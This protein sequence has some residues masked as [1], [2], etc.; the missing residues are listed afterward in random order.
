[1]TR[2]VVVLSLL[3]RCLSR[4]GGELQTTPAKIAKMVMACC[5]LHN[6]VEM[7]RLPLPE[8]L[9][10]DANLE[11]GNDVSLFCLIIVV[12]QRS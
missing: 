5:V 3:N 8:G 7:A 12:T 11:E 10:F 6:I 4:S 2:L 9:E 1:M